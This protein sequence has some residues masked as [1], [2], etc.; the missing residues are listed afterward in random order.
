MITNYKYKDSLT[1]DRNLFWGIIFIGFSLGMLVFSGL[2]T[3]FMRIIVN[4]NGNQLILFLTI[5][6]LGIFVISMIQW[7]MSSKRSYAWS[8]IRL[9]LSIIFWAML[10]SGLFHLL[11]VKDVA[12][13]SPSSLFL[14]MLAPILIMAIA[15]VLSFFDISMHKLSIVMSLLLVAFIIMAIISIFAYRAYFWVLL[16]QGAIFT[17]NSLFAFRQIRQ[18][19]MFANNKLVLNAI[20][21]TTELL[22]NYFH[23]LYVVVRLLLIRSRD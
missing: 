11:L 4:G 10:F 14:I 23:L 18:A 6:S 20:F 7:F 5:G 15:A 22:N 16:L 2:L 3:I 12:G 21:W 19:E 1:W 13:F 8:S 9:F 17:I